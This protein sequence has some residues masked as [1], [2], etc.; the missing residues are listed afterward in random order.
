MAKAEIRT[1]SK[2]G[3]V[4]KDM[5]SATVVEHL[6]D[7]V[8]EKFLDKVIDLAGVG[9]EKGS[10]A[11]K[12]VGDTLGRWTYDQ[13]TKPSY[14]K[15]GDLDQAFRTKTGAYKGN[16]RPEH[17]FFNPEQVVKQETGPYET[18]CRVTKK[19]EPG[20]GG[21]VKKYKECG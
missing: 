11:Y 5:L 14:S 13:L 17:A 20:K 15:E 3:N 8:G 18:A 7:S 10:E 21:F 6:M 4:A 2:G 1:S 12:A 19:G 9:I 16:V